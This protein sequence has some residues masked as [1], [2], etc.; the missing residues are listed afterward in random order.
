MGVTK[1]NSCNVEP[2][3]SKKEIS[4]QT[5][6]AYFA[7]LNQVIY[8]IIGMMFCT[9]TMEDDK[10]GKEKEKKTKFTI[11]TKTGY[12]V[13][14]EFDE[15]SRDYIKCMIRGLS[16]MKRLREI[17]LALD[18]VPP[19]G[20]IQQQL[21][22]RKEPTR[23]YDQKGNL[24]FSD[25]WIM[26]ETWVTKNFAKI[27]DELFSDYV[28]EYNEKNSM[29][30]LLLVKSFT[31]V[32]GEGEHKVLDM[33][34]RSKYTNPSISNGED[35]VLVLSN[36]GDTIVSVLSQSLMNVYFE[37][38]VFKAGQFEKK[39]VSR[40]DVRDSLSSSK[41][42]ALNI[43]PILNF[44]GND[45]LPEL[46]MTVDLKAF[47]TR[48]RNLCKIETKEGS[49]IK[50]KELE[51]VTSY[52]DKDK[53]QH[54]LLDFTN[55]KKLFGLMKDIEIEMYF[56]RPKNRDAQFDTRTH[57]KPKNDLERVCFKRNY[58]EFVYQQ[59]HKHVLCKTPP[60]GSENFYTDD[61]ILFDFE[62]ELS[63][64]YMKTFV[65]YYY[66]QTGFHVG[67]PLNNSFYPYGYPPLVN[68]LYILLDRMKELHINFS[69]EDNP[70]LIPVERE[71]D[72]FEKLQN[73]GP[74]HHYMVLQ[75]EDLR[76]LYPDGLDIFSDIHTNMVKQ[77]PIVL[78]TRFQ[79]RNAFQKIELYPRVDIDRLLDIHGRHLYRVSEQTKKTNKIGEG[80]IETNTKKGVLMNKFSLSAKIAFGELPMKKI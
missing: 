2:Q 23:Y 22:R 32:P 59:Y 4:D 70:V 19:Y 52:T 38:N 35:S 10:K 20:K 31:D 71:I 37:T 61:K 65:W 73:F 14:K 44:V 18:G 11:R 80:D 58:Y 57:I 28:K 56:E 39:V 40:D 13:K 48:I 1:F 29:K 5:C 7:D 3:P 54:M 21:R 49:M 27:I 33:L 30:K 34:R 8:T 26:P 62:M 36:D 15:M 76:G 47:Y 74:L 17:Y 79:V 63:L 16:K 45:Y 77:R 43:L 42:E 41:I 25:A 68:S 24:L 60:H 67:A 6:V 9:V 12:D 46:L 53:N 78:D 64:S 55:L 66:Y 51:L 72:Y 75:E 69:H 50:I